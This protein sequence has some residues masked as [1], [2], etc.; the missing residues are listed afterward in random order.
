MV[1]PT[2]L[3]YTCQKRNHRTGNLEWWF[4][5]G[6]M[7]RLLPGDPGADPKASKAYWDHLMGVARG[8]RDRTIDT[9]IASY[10]KSPA[11]TSK[12]QLTR[13]IYSRTLAYIAEASGK[14]AADR[15]KRSDVIEARDANAHRPGA[16]NRVVIL[17]SIIMEHAIDMDWRTDNPAKGVKHFKG[18]EGHK[19]WPPWAIANFRA[20]AVGPARTAFE[21]CLGTGQRIGD[22][23]A[24]R[25]DDIEDDEIFVK[26]SKTGV[27]L[28]IPFTDDLRSYLE[29]LPRGLRTTIVCN[30]HGEPYVYRNLLRLFHRSREA[31][32][33]DDF[34]PHGLRYNAA[35]ELYEAGCTDAQVQAITGHKTRA[36][37]AKYGKGAS[38]RRL[39]REARGR[40][41]GTKTESVVQSVVAAD[42]NAP[43]D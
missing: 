3:R 17:M 40:K 27:E 37:A 12:A 29:A 33:A 39:A 24:M 35:S 32:G 2:R 28:W 21:L 11:F 6:K 15:I 10:K 14:V 7:W 9:L 26:Q 41:N 23:L 30:D 43:D 31:A 13:K 34:K 16:A 42:R 18:G 25:W 38:Q 5:K 20:V 4:R 19:P 1:K 8:P 22:V 36:M